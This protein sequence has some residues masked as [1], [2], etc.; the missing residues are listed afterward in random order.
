MAAVSAARPEANLDGMTVNERLL[1]LGLVEAF[2]AAIVSRNHSAAVHVLRK[3]KL[4]PEQAQQTVSAI[5]SDPKRYG[6]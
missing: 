4:T 2:D 6:F 1:E 5:F 3:A